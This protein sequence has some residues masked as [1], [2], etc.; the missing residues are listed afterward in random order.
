LENIALAMLEYV[1]S[2]DDGLSEMRAGK[3]WLAR[4]TNSDTI[5]KDMCAVF[6]VGNYL[7]MYVTMVIGLA[8]CFI[9]VTRLLILSTSC[10]LQYANSIDS[11]KTVGNN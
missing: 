11:N 1:F 6:A 3:Y 8:G 9:A 4:A 5:Y 10:I 7:H 2:V